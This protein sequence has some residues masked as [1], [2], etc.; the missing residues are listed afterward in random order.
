M[1][2]EDEIRFLRKMN[3]RQVKFLKDVY[4]NSNIINYKYLF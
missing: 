2:F 3:K 4:R 1:L